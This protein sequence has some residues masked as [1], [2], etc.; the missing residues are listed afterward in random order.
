MNLDSFFNGAHI[1][2]QHLSYSNALAFD[3]FASDPG[4]VSLCTEEEIFS[5]V[6]GNGF[7]VNGDCSSIN[8]TVE[9]IE[10]SL[11]YEGDG[12]VNQGGQALVSVNMNNPEE[13]A[14]FE[15]HIQD[16]PESMSSSNADVTASA[17][18]DAIGGMLSVSEV[19]G[20]LVVLWFSL[21]GTTIPAEFGESKQL[22]FVAIAESILCALEL[23]ERHT[24]IK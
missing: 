9:G 24:K 19:N 15:L 8:M 17:E 22:I 3:A 2:N 23:K 18:L 7:P 20:E 6:N 11:H 10:V 1:R 16:S 21:D 14:G 4:A 13:I 5:D 12:A